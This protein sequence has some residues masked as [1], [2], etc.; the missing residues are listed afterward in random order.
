MTTS[1]PDASLTQ[2]PQVRTVAHSEREAAIAAITLAFVA[3]PAARWIFPQAHVYSRVMPGLADAFGGP[4]I[5]HDAA[6]A[7]A[8]FEGV[9]L[10]LPPGV[11]PDSERL[12]ALLSDAVEAERID[13]V[14]ELFA[15]MA[16][17]HPHERHWYLPL[18]G[19]D[20]LHQGRGHGAALMRHVLARC[21]DEGVAAYLESSNPRNISLYE[22]H[23][24]EVLGTIQF[25]DSPVMTPMLRSP[26]AER[27]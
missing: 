15:R 2:P 10:W 1:A 18:I 17:H 24:F 3:D 23:G 13:S 21:D 7:T 8:G 22:R 4:G 19:V 27:S 9:A 14:N 25:G 5:V 11:E 16:D 20:P 26:R 6:F 12:S